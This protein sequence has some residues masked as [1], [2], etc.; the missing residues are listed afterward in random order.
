MRRIKVLQLS[1][2]TGGVQRYVIY[3]AGCLNKGLFEGVGCCPPI[4]RIPG[5]S[6]QK[7]SFA[8][9]FGRIGIRVVPIEM[10]REIRPLR[11]LKSFFQIYRL[12]RKEKFDVVH[13]HSS[14][15]GF[16]GRLA[17]RLAGV[18]VVVHTP[19]NFAFD[20]PRQTPSRLLYRFL[21]TIASFFCDRIL[22]VSVSEEKLA[23]KVAPRGKVVR[24]DN[25]IDLQEVVARKNPLRVREELGLVPGRPVVSMVGRL[26]VQK[27]PEDF[28]LAAREVLQKK[29]E[30]AFLVMGD[31]PL[32]QETEGLIRSLNL[33]KQI[34]L[35]GWRE[36]VFDLMAAS[37]LI[38]LTSLWEGLP[39]TVLDAMAFGKPLVVTDATGSVDVV[40]D[41]VTGLVVSRHNPSEVAKAILRLLDHPAEAKRMGEAGRRFME[42]EHLT[43]RQ[44]VER[45]QSL[46]LELLR[47]KA[48]ERVKGI[49]P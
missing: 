29:Q 39:Y 5:V 41:G 35:L 37:D 1:Q 34:L 15:A 23:L 30:V 33:E 45:I 17:A 11:D 32:W 10:W 26:S 49:F 44:Q 25:A 4:D 48:P 21:E 28:V 12:I 6:R 36:D 13:T 2:A 46:Y 19:N 8:E 31:G 42:K 9:A 38:V 22:A 20:R 27:C 3:L 47:H 7:E 43:L 40:Q 16:V 18:P 24:I 14:K